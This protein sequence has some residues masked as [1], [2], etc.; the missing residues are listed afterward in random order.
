MRGVIFLILILPTTLANA[1]RNLGA[2]PEPAIPAMVDLFRSHDIVMFGETHGN[3]QEY[4]WLC[5]LVKT[6]AFADR[7]N[8]I[9]VEFGNSLYQKT[10]DRYIAGENIP[11][12]QI[13]KAWLNMIGAVAD[14][15]GVGL[16]GWA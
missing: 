8:D 16:M 14:F 12:A 1:E 13:T 5:N 9:V 15:A 10:A 11:Q 3:K 2:K 4:E 7:V 6:P